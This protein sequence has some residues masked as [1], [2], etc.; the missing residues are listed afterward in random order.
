[1]TKLSIIV[2]T[3]KRRERLIQTF[4]TFILSNSK[5]IEFIIVDNN[6]EDGTE[7]LIFEYAQKDKRIKYF[8]NQLNIGPN[9]NI[10]RGYLESKSD[11]IMI[12]PDDDFI[13][14]GFFEEVLEAIEDNNDCGLIIT[15]KENEKIPYNDT[16]RLQASPESFKVAYNFSGVITCLC[17]NK[18]F[19]NQVEW[20]LDNSIYPQIRL[21][22]QISLISEILFLIPKNKPIVGDWGDDI[23]NLE[24]PSDFGV[25][26]RIKTLNDVSK[27]IT[28]EKLKTLF[29]LE[30]GL[31]FWATNLAVLMS[32]RNEN[33]SKA[34][35]KHLFTSKVLKK[36]ALFIAISFV[37]LV[38]KK[39]E[40]KLNYVVLTETLKALPSA[41]LNLDFYRGGF[42]LLM[43]QKKYYESYRKNV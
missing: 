16:K 37:N 29:E 20:K 41:L 17:F 11:W 18:K 19:L 39:R 5:D 24:R 35:I 25:F 26:E 42:F 4:P 15:A 33:Y 28:S 30:I 9:R 13:K 10:Y 40:K 27:R 36:S 14:P 1:M 6:S 43:N 21:A 12:L 22:T 32:K 2:P 7:E 38:L 23:T 8:K 3:Y 34:Y 31:Y